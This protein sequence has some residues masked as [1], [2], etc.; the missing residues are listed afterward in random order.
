MLYGMKLSSHHT[1]YFMLPKNVCT[2]LTAI[3]K[4]KASCASKDVY[5]KCNFN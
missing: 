2:S 4:L 5:R 3:S 1:T